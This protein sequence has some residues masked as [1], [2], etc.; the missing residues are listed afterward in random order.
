MDLGLTNKTVLITGST[1]GIGKAIALELAREGAIPLINGRK[2]EAVE[3]AIA[4]IKKRAA[5]CY[6]K[7]CYS[8]YHK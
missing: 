5:K 6:C 8:R 4:E 1:K 3:Q 2:Q 7:S